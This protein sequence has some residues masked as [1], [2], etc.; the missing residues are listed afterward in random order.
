MPDI[1][2][3][4]TGKGGLVDQL[5]E[6]ILAQP[7]ALSATID[8]LLGAQSGSLDALRT[9]G[10]A[11]SRP[12]DAVVLTGMGSSFYALPIA[13]ITLQQAGIPCVVLEASELMHY[14]ID[15]LTDRTLLLV[16]SQSG[17]SIEIVRLVERIDERGAARRPKL[18]SLSSNLDNSLAR[19]ADLALRIQAGTERSIAIKTHSC[20]QVA[21]AMIATTLCGGDPRQT[22]ERL[23][24][25]VGALDRLLSGWET[26]LEPLFT[27]FAETTK[28][29]LLGRGWSLVS[30]AAGALALKEGGHVAAEG[31]SVGAFRH[32]TFELAGPG[33]DVVIF[34]SDPATAALNLRLAEEL[35]GFDTRVALVRTAS[36]DAEPLGAGDG[37]VLTIRLPAIE[38]SLAPLLEVAVAQLW[39]RHLAIAQGRTPGELLRLPKVIRVE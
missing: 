36:D 3:Q 16:V 24:T 38:P 26:R 8:D 7:E 28:P 2:V 5:L 39:S 20:T 1:T 18:I 12:F 11:D 27:Y 33:V 13:A 32:G 35:A 34:A 14:Q 25:A 29:F 31:M 23:R 19:A 6:E 30:A 22:G 17:E 15:V 37:S 9:L 21:L 4:N 10:R